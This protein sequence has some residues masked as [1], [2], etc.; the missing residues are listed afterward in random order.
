MVISK[1]V[2]AQETQQNENEGHASMLG[3]VYRS[4]KKVHK[5]I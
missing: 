3:Q 5:M 4:K 1:P 2:L